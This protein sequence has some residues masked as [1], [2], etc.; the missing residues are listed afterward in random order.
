MTFI[1]GLISSSFICPFVLSVLLSGSW[2]VIRVTSVTPAGL[3]ARWARSG[4]WAS[5]KPTAWWLL[6]RRPRTHRTDVVTVDEVMG[7]YRFS[8]TRW[9]TSLLL[10]VPNWG[11]RNLQQQTPRR[12]GP[13][14]SWTRKDQRKRCGPAAER[15]RER[16]IVGLFQVEDCDVFSSLSA[17]DCVWMCVCVR[18]TI[19][20][21]IFM[22]DQCKSLTCEPQLLL[23]QHRTLIFI[24][25][26]MWD[27]LLGNVVYICDLIVYN[28]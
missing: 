7:R 2:W 10:L 16:G 4:R 8:R 6:R 23:L 12:T 18:M 5:P 15:Q 25:L 13:L 22:F 9:R 3:T 28:R 21:I 19:M 26:N 17:H 24:L 20:C 1:Q 14:K 11:D 27:V